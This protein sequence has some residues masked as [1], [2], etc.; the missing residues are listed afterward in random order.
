MLILTAR[1]SITSYSNFLQPSLIGSEYPLKRIEPN[2]SPISISEN[3]HGFKIFSPL[4]V[5]EMGKAIYIL[6][7]TKLV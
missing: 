1:E 4:E 3:R 2:P 6:L 7:K 5:Q